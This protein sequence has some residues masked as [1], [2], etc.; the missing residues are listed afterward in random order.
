MHHRHHRGHVD[1]IHNIKLKEFAL[2]IS[3]QDKKQQHHHQH[4]QDIIEDDDSRT[5]HN[6]M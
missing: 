3:K 2:G 4:L 6:I 5:I 1:L